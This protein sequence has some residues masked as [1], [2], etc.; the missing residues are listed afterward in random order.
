Y[1][2]QATPD[3]GS[4]SADRSRPRYQPPAPA[5]GGT[6]S[7]APSLPLPGTVWLQGPHQTRQI[8]TSVDDCAPE[9]QFT[10]VRLPETFDA[11]IYVDAVTPAPV[12]FQVTGP[13]HPVC[14]AP[15]TPSS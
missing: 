13:A 10:S 11:V 14:P 8:E 3:S 6:P 9:T 7:P 2:A 4:S 12:L 1:P 15:A 5:V